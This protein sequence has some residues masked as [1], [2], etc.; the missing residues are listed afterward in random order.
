MRLNRFVFVIA[1]CCLANSVNSTFA[2]RILG[3]TAEFTVNEQLVAA[4]TPLTTL[5]AIFAGQQS[6]S[7]TLDAADAGNPFDAIVGTEKTFTLM[8]N[9]DSPAAIEGRPNN[10]ATDLDFDPNDLLGSWTPGTDVGALL[11][12]GEQV[13]L[14][15]MTR[16]QGTF[17]GVLLFGDFAVRYSP[18]RTDAIRSGLVL[19]NNVDFANTTYADLAN[20]SS[21]VSDS[22]ILI[23]GDLLFAEGFASLTNDPSDVGVQFGTFELNLTTVPEPTSLAIVGF[24]CV[25]MLSL[26]RRS[27]SKA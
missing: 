12:G 24:G 20:I 23:S 27:R 13:G 10:A 3:G 26:R 7:Q 19:V 11:L 25:A 9:G 4:A 18:T 1:I 2:G 5:N 17:D 6:Y 14:Q 16:W 15:G 8:V 22:S 21:H